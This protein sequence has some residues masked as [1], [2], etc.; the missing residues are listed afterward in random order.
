MKKITEVSSSPLLQWSNNMLQAVPARKLALTAMI[1]LKG[2]HAVIRPALILPTTDKIYIT[3][4]TS[5][6]GFL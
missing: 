2:H 4:P 1:T 6:K 5:K 3:I